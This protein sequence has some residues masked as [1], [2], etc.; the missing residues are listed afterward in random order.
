[1]VE[2][3]AVEAPVALA[4]LVPAL[5][6]LVAPV[7][8]GREMVKLTVVVVV[9]VL[10][11]VSAAAALVALEEEHLEQVP[12]VLTVQDLVLQ[13]LFG[14]EITLEVAEVVL[15]DPETLGQ[16]LQVTGLLA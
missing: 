5:A 15:P 6:V 8:R 13:H 9:A 3:A 14:Q 10:V 2:A 11:L 4:I 1:V 12:A 7:Q 16:V